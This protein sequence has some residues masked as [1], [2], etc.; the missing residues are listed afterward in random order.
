MGNFFSLIKNVLYAMN[1]RDIF[2]QNS[3]ILVRDPDRDRFATDADTL[4]HV[5]LQCCRNH[6]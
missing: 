4:M 3:R 5:I 1:V 2:T 6:K